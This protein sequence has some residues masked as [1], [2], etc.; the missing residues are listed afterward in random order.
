MTATMFSIGLIILIIFRVIWLNWQKRACI[1]G[2]ITDLILAS[3]CFALVFEDSDIVLHFAY[4][5]CAITWFILS[6][7]ELYNLRNS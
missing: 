1:L 2:F 6:L 5:F 7:V 4:I 3:G